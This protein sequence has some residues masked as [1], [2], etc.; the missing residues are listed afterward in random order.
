M[1]VVLQ[2]KSWGER[3]YV[4]ICSFSFLSIDSLKEIVFFGSRECSEQIAR[5]RGF[6]ASNL[7]K[8]N[9]QTTVFTYKL[10]TT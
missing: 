4:E 1:V 10:T 3:V 8:V 9:S 5:G 6:K 7:A 2:N